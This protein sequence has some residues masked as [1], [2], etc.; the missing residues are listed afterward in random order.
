M[1]YINLEPL[2]QMYDEKVMDDV[3]ASLRRMMIEESEKTL[4]DSWYKHEIQYLSLI[5]HGD[6]D[7]VLAYFDSIKDSARTRY[8]VHDKLLQARYYTVCHL[9][10]LARAAIKGGML[11]NESFG[12]CDIYIQKSA[13]IHDA[14]EVMKLIATAT[15]DYTARVNKIQTAPRYSRTISFCCNYI[16]EHIH[17][18]ISLDELSRVCNLS[19]EYLSRLFK[20]E[21]GLTIKK[22]ALDKKLEAAGYLLI[23]TNKS[24]QEISA[25]L[26]FS[27]HGRFSGYFHAKYGVT[28]KEYRDKN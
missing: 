8:D 18:N 24:V 10:L 1:Y 13:E 28:P 14:H 16:A 3:S 7:G 2:Q 4:S 9:T 5:E 23:N 27:S 15:L 20:K 12:L 21:T 11:E 6:V 25:F 26:G 22:Y 19:K 17:I